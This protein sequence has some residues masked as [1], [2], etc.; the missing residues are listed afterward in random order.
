M[1]LK[2]IYS[3]ET[4]KP[5]KLDHIVVKH[6]GVSVEQNFSRRL[7][8]GA[9]AEGWMTLSRGKIIVHAKPEDLVYTVKRA[10]GH[11][12]VHCGEKL[13]SDT[14]GQGARKHV[15][16]KHAGAKSPDPQWPHG[17]AVTNAFECVLDEKQHAKFKATPI[18]TRKGGK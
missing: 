3:N 4:G 11:Y 5:P 17:Y 7:V 14:N 16:E 2:R 18:G 12:C 8:E 6:T 10:P 9:V 15:A 1:L 13:D